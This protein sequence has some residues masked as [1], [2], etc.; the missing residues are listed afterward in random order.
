[1]S[2]DRLRFQGEHPQNPNP[3]N[4]LGVYLLDSAGNRELIYR[5]PHISSTNP[6]PIAA[7]PVPP[8]LP[9]ALCGEAESEGEM[10]VSDVYRGLGDVARGTIKHLRVVQ[11]FPKTTPVANSPRI[12]LAGEENARAILGTVPV[13]P[14]GSVRFRVPAHKPLLFQALD[15][16]GFAFQTMRSTTY[17][18]PG[19]QVACVGCHEPRMSAPPAHVPL[20]LQ[21][22]PRQIDPGEFGGRPFSYVEVV[23]PV[24]D[25]HCVRCHGGERTDGDLDLS[26]NRQD[27]F[28]RSYWSLCGKDLDGRNPGTS[29]DGKPPLVPRFWQRNQIQLT[30]PGGR[31]GALGSGLMRLLREGHEGVQL[32]AGEMRRLAAW[33]DMNAIFY[34]AY[35]SERQARQLDG[36]TIPMPQI[37]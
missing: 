9:S 14:D 37:Q 18:Q 34:G 31:D 24:L 2:R 10:V 25:D 28:T 4:A 12:G 29:A 15:A 8:V 11:I 16:D 36:K 35:E 33:I 6:I 23:Q 30:L 32:N 1:Y 27:G 20:A 7:R 17:V 5:D 19:E 22:P 13:E 21:Q 3:D 26:G